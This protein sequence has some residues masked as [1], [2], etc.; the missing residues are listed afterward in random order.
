M[1]Q[2]LRV[3]VTADVELLASRYSMFKIAVR[4][5]SL[6]QAPLRYTPDLK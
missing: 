3:L 4:S 1:S 2:V 6:M 5:E